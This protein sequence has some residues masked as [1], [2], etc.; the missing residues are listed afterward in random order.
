MEVRS[1]LA[2]R[3]R[4][5]AGRLAPADARSYGRIICHLNI[6]CLGSR[7]HRGYDPGMTNDGIIHL[8][9]FAKTVG[10][11]LNARRSCKSQRSF[12]REWKELCLEILQDYKEKKRAELGR[13]TL[14]WLWMRDKIMEPFDIRRPDGKAEPNPKLVELT[15]QNLESWEKTGSLTDAKFEY[16]DLFVRSLSASASDY[17]SF[18]AARRRI[19]AYQM[20]IFSR[21]YQSKS[22]IPADAENIANFLGSFLVSGSLVKNRFKYIV[23]RID[24]VSDGVIKVVMAYC[25]FDIH[26]FNS[27]EAE[28]AVFYDA[29]LVP[30]LTFLPDDDSKFNGSRLL[31]GCQCIAKL[32]RPEFRGHH[33][34]GYADGE[35]ELHFSTDENQKITNSA[36]FMDAPN[37]MMAPSIIEKTVSHEERAPEVIREIDLHRHI[38]D[39]NKSSSGLRHPNDKSDIHKYRLYRLSEFPV[40]NG[41]LEEKLASIFDNNYSGYLF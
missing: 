39:S 22:N 40:P 1:G 10:I 30:V 11:D 12:P 5:R 14:G 20:A 29:Y 38:Q 18:D 27:R 32:F 16:I 33:I 35:V 17:S 31:L 8:H 23:L 26:Y 15:R 21:L 24:F 13:K 34:D 36:I 4:H 37:T 3:G 25:P 6:S 7:P 19:D 28:E 9:E 2:P 41:D